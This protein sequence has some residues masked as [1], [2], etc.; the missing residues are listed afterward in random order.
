MFH[1]LELCLFAFCFFAARK[2][3]MLVAVGLQIRPN[4]LFC[5]LTFRDEIPCLALLDWICNPAAFVS[6][7][8]NICQYESPTEPS[9]VKK[10]NGENVKKALVPWYTKGSITIAWHFNAFSERH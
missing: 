8:E 9:G 5:F 1:I 2:M 6:L 4:R 10:I 7:N 3:P